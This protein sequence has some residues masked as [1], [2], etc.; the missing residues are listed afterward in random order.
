MAPFL[1]GERDEGGDGAPCCTSLGC[2]G[3][4]SS[5]GATAP[6][7]SVGERRSPKNETKG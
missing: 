4:G 2:T 5:V 3:I 1:G 7:G 6:C